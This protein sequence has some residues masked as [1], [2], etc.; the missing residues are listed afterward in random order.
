MSAATGNEQSP[1]SS[2][3]K[4]VLV[5]HPVVAF[6]IMAYALGWIIML[7]TSEVGLPL[8]FVSSLGVISGVALPAFL[9]TAATDGKAGVRDLLRRCFRWRGRHI[10]VLAGASWTSRR[11]VAR[12]EHV[13]GS[14][15]ASGTREGRARK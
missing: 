9:V 2:S 3:L 14:R 13:P 15:T 1:I 6:L 7:A 11:Y 8:R 12:R 5:R 4:G 10:L